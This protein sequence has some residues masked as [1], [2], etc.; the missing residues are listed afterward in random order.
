MERRMHQKQ[1]KGSLT[2]EA[3]LFLTIFLMAFLTIINFGKLARA[4]IVVQHAINDSALQ[5][6]QYSYVLTKAGLIDPMVSTANGAKQIRSDANQII[7]A[8]NEFSDA[9]DG[10]TSGSVTEGDVD[11]LLAAVSDAQG[12]IDIATGYFKN[13]KGLF[14]GLMALAKDDIERR[15]SMLIVSR[16]AESQVEAYFEE[17]TDD[18]DA[19]LENL[20]IVGGMDGLD[21]SE[22]EYVAGGTKDIN[23]TVHFTVKNQ[24]FPMLSFGEHE[25]YLN[26]STRIW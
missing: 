25:M 2:V 7:G 24:M 10:V 21:F 1:E 13:P 26:A 9:V 23:I 17:I 6:S 12:A 11:Q 20:G 8:V 14:T 22:S 4:Q 3:V 16:I 18:P 19:Y 15:A 5:I